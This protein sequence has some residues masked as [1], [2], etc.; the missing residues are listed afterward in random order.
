[1]L[2]KA[3]HEDITFFELDAPLTKEAA[4]EFLIAQGLQENDPVAE[5]R[6]ARAAE[7]EA[8]AA[9]R[10]AAR[11]AKQTTQEPSSSLI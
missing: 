4:T 7:R 3:G 8:K 2:I 1:M 10:A 9:E 6:A 5:A 11:A